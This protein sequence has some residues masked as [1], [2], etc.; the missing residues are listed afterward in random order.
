VTI[1]DDLNVAVDAKV[2]GGE[3]RAFGRTANGTDVR[4][5]QPADDPD[6]PALTLRIRQTF[7]GIEVIE[8]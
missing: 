1:P 8:R 7:G 3:I 6:Q 2:D 5:V 4:L